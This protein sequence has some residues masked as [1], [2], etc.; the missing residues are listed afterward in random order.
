MSI[1]NKKL[2]NNYD[3]LCCDVRHNLNERNQ[4]PGC[5]HYCII[6]RSGESDWKGKAGLRL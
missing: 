1:N 5:R 6:L 3:V 4:E 2:T